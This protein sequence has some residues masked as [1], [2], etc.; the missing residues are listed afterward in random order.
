METVSPS[1]RLG[2]S[3]LP[4]L[5]ALVVTSTQGAAPTP[6]EPA[7]PGA[8]GWARHTPGGR[9]GRII[10]VTTL[11]AKGPGSFAEA[12][13]ARGPRII[14]F[15]VGGIIDLAGATLT[16]TE[17]FATI[18]GQTAPSPGIT[19]I[20]GGILLQG[21]DLVVR[22][23]RV[24]P[25]EAGHAKKSGWEIDGLSTLQGSHD[26]I[27]DHCSFTWATDENLSVSGKFFS[28]ET[29]EDWRRNTSRRV[30]FSDNIIAEGLHASTHQKVLHSKGTLV[31]D[32]TSDIA[33]VGNLYANNVERNPQIKGGAWAVIVNNYIRNPAM[34]A[35]SYHL[36]EVWIKAKHAPVNGRIALVGNHLQY[37][38][39]TR[40]GLALFGFAGFGQLEFYAADNLAEDRTGRPAPLVVA[41]SRDGGKILE[42]PPHFY[43]PE[44][45]TARPVAEVKE[46][47]LREAGAR[48][49]DRDAIDTRIVLE[50]R[51]GTGRVINSEQEGGGY[52]S[53]PETRQPFDPAAWDLSTMTRRP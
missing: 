2:S 6:P 30:T 33:I 19:F 16:I 25:G 27:V 20:R 52:P 39:D 15:E 10:R 11:A 50:A 41:S 46:R 31:M 4:L 18:A 42:Q 44:G 32:N 40:T 53:A 13:A 5:L 12:I 22:H 24:R 51:N 7:F 45:L 3:I 21:H 36:T 43:W 1:A 48:P 26:I 37:G 47:V 49:W 8:V 9:G 14:V 35:V 23:I 38:P 28:G 34:S 29:P 17:P